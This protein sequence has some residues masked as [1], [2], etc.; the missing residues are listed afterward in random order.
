MSIDGALQE[1]RFIVARANF[2]GWARTQ[3]NWGRAADPG[4]PRYSHFPHGARPAIGVEVAVIEDREAGDDEG[5]QVSH[6]SGSRGRRL[7]GHAAT[8]ADLLAGRVFH[9]FLQFSIEISACELSVAELQ[10]GDDPI[11]G[12][13]QERDCRRQKFT[14]LSRV[15]IQI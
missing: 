6:E 2:R 14:L 10:Q 8:M 5:G 1:G 4:F 3:P 13:G 15:A 9:N 11:R 12:K 7:G